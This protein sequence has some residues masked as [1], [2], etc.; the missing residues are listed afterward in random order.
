M[1]LKD[2]FNKAAKD[3]KSLD[4]ASNEELLAL[5]SLYKQAT[6]GDVSGKKPGAF[7][8]KGKAKYEAWS[9]KAGMS[10]EEAM[11]EYVSLVKKL[12]S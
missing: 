11:K 7:D 5:Y 9:K 8:L 3:V 10:K 2:E 4:S 1:A 6:V 12:L